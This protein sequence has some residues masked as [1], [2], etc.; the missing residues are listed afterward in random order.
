[1]RWKTETEPNHG[2][3]RFITKFLLFPKTIHG[4]TRWLETACWKEQCEFYTFP[5]RFKYDW[6]VIQWS[7]K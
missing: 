3:V 1:M 5:F 7:D 6:R 2:D 4:E